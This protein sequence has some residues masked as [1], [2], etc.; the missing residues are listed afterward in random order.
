MDLFSWQAIFFNGHIFIFQCESNENFVERGKIA[1]NEHFP[2]LSV[3][4]ELNL[5]HLQ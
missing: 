3:Q 1:C 4:P 5:H 2:Y